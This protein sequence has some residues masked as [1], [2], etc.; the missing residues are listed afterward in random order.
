MEPSSAPTTSPSTD[1]S[2]PARPAVDAVRALLNTRLFV[3]LR[4]RRSVTGFLECFDSCGNIVLRDGEDVTR[5]DNPHPL[6]LILAPGG[7]YDAVSVKR[8]ATE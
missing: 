1:A 7:S 5:P 8:D 4:D 6:G 3:T 2:A